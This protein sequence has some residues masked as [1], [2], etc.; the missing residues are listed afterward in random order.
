MTDR[1]RRR[2]AHDL[3]LRQRTQHFSI[4]LAFDLYSIQLLQRGMTEDEVLEI[5]R[6][7]NDDFTRLTE[8]WSNDTPDK[9]YSFEVLDRQLRELAPVNYIPWEERYKEIL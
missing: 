5:N 3:R 6:G 1:E 9:E 4:Q 8:I 2:A 7:V